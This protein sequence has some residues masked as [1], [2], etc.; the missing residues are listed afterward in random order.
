MTAA[1]NDSIYIRETIDALRISVSLFISPTLFQTLLKIDN[2]RLFLVIRIS[3]IVLIL[4]VMAS[5][6]MEELERELA[7]QKQIV[8][9]LTEKWKQDQKITVRQVREL[10]DEIQRDEDNSRIATLTGAS[11][12]I[13]GGSIA[14]AG[15][16][17]A[18]FTF[19][20]SLVLTAVGGA[21]SGVGGVTVLG[22]EITNGVLRSGKFK[23]V[24][25]ALEKDKDAT[26]DLVEELENLEGI[27]KKRNELIKKNRTF[28]IAKLVWKVGITV[29]N[30]VETGIK[31]ANAGIEAWETVFKSLGRSGKFFRVGGLA[32]S[33]WFVAWDIYTLVKTSIDVHKGSKL[34]VVKDIHK[35]AQALE[36][37]MEKPFFLADYEP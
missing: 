30:E 23:E 31:L 33:P 34:E 10:A 26:S 27:L 15:G 13:V 5:R 3:E 37:E 6:T 1:F 12:A 24:E 14:I 21:I 18:F 28:L 8:K 20:A 19:G 11:A 4:R 9:T 2:K 25:K 35:V 17:C 36:D 16:V 32:L 29:S 7:K 22:T